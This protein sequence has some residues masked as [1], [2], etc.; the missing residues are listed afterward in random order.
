MTGKGSVRGW[1]DGG[2]GVTEGG[3]MG[4]GRVRGWSN[5]GKGRVRGWNE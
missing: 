1:S 5:G 4:K 3:V 2:K